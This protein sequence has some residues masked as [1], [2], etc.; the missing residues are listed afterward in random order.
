[1]EKR[2][3]Q[4]QK[5]TYFLLPLPGSVSPLFGVRLRIRGIIVLTML[6][7]SIVGESIAIRKVNERKDTGRK[8][9]NP[10]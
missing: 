1:L 10:A 4:H 3:F 9:G 2:L 5:F 8:T 6:L 7:S